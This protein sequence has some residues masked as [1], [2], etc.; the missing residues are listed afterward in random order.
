VPSGPTTQLAPQQLESVAKDEDPVYGPL[1][2]ARG[3]VERA[4]IAD[5]EISPDL[6]DELQMPSQ[7]L[8]TAD[9]SGRR[10]L[11]RI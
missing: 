8:V 3:K 4:L 10:G 7:S 5:N 6:A 1:G 2:R 9:L 11:I